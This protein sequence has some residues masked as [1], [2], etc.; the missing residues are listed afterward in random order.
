MVFWNQRQAI[1]Q[2]VTHKVNPD[3]SIGEETARK[4]REGIVREAEI[5]VVMDLSVATSLRD[6]LDGH[7]RQI[8]A[9]RS[10]EELT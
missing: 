9:L 2:Q 3:G 8:E 5:A 10:E 1:P 7:L 6:W 4:A